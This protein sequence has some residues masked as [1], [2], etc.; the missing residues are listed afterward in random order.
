MVQLNAM[1]TRRGWSCRPLRVRKHTWLLSSWL[2]GWMARNGWWLNQIFVFSRDFVR[3]CCCDLSRTGSRLSA[4]RG[5]TSWGSLLHGFH[6]LV[7]WTVELDAYVRTYWRAVMKRTPL[8]SRWAERRSSVV[9]GMF[10]PHCCWT[11][12][13]CCWV[14]ENNMG[15]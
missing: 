11:F 14:K 12:L 4:F 3:Y 10:L 8:T 9:Y 13:K 5:G 6:T 1:K 7:W 2:S 15:K